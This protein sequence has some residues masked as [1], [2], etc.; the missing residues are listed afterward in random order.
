MPITH[1]LDDVE[2]D[3]FEVLVDEPVAAPEAVQVV[4]PAPP[5]SNRIGRPAPHGGAWRVR[6]DGSREQVQ[7]PTERRH[8]HF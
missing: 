7:A 1:R 6:Q 8:K 2:D 3:E 4:S 5:S